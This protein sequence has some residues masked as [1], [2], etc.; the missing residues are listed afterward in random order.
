MTNLGNLLKQAQAMQARVEELQ[1][2]LAEAEVEGRAGGGLVTAVMDGRGELKRVRI[3][4]SLAS[5]DEVE[6]LEDL[7]V[8]ACAEAKAKVE[9]LAGEEM[10][11]LTGGVP[12]PPGLKLF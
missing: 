5:P 1:H 6:V 2:K 11:K 8:A 12:L 10:R 4:P 3:D 9:T 7:I